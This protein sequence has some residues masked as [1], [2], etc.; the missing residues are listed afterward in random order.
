MS[1]WRT[2]PHDETGGVGERDVRRDFVSRESSA[3]G[4]IVTGAAREKYRAKTDLKIDTGQLGKD[5]GL[6]GTG[7]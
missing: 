5:E 3:L 4:A 7:C 1:C 6:R 2:L